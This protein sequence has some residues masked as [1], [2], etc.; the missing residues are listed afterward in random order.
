MLFNCLTEF[1]LNIYWHTYT[2]VLLLGAM[3]VV[4]SLLLVLHRLSKQ[5]LELRGMAIVLLGGLLMLLC[6]AE[7]I[8]S[9]SYLYYISMLV[10]IPQVLKND[11]DYRKYFKTY[12]SL[13]CIYF[14]TSIFFAKNTGLWQPISPAV[15]QLKF[16]I[17]SVITLEL[18]LMFTYMTAYYDKQHARALSEQKDKAEEAMKARVR[19]LSNMG[20]E[21]RTPLNGIIGANQLLKDERILPEQEQYISIISYCSKHMLELVNNILDFNK[22]EAGKVELHYESINLNK[23]LN[24]ALM[25]FHN[26]FHKKGVCL[27]SEIDPKLNANIHADD[28]RLI[29]VI[30]NL[31]SNALKFTEQGCVKLLANLLEEED[32]RIRVKISVEDTG[33][34]LDP[35]AC[36][37]V[38]ERFWQQYNESTRKYS[39]TGLG[40]SICNMLLM[41][42]GSKLELTSTKGIGSTFTFSLWFDKVTEPV[43][44]VPVEQISAKNLE[45][46]NI[47]VAED[48]Q[49]NMTIITK[50]LAKWKSNVTGCCNGLETLKHLQH[51]S[52]YDLI[53]L[54]LEMPEMD[55]FTAIKEIKRLYPHIPVLAFSAVLMDTE[56]YQQLIE[57]GFTDCVLKPFKAAELYDKLRQYALPRGSKHEVPEGSK[58]SSMLN[59]YEPVQ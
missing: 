33:I 13:I 31:V 54:D 40:L 35:E 39:G 24:Q 51:C 48:N 38:F 32:N 45:G 41:M 55:G 43:T 3:L 14:L 56:M 2:T 42:M 23:L 58:L 22:I 25:P 27:V 29:Q 11:N 17:N 9:G 18:T 36:V 49:I 44:V 15:Y 52:D 26:Q 20:H 8:K 59:K 50:T 30:N 5:R 28:M 47:L 34:G 7:G 21:L 37:K 10:A 4:M 6:L 16:Y 57:M 12:I 1:C 46:V 53:L 19:F